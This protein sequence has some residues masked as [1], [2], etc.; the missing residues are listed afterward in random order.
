LKDNHD[1]LIAKCQEGDIQAFK[2]LYETEKEKVYN[3]CFRIHGN[4]HD[5]QDSVQDAFVLTFNKIKTFRGDAAFSTWFYRIIVNT[6]L[7]NIRRS[8]RHSNSRSLDDFEIE[9]ERKVQ[10][11]QDT[12]VQMVLEQEIQQLPTGYRTVFILYEIEGF[13][14]EEIGEILNISTNT[15]KSQLHRGKKI[16]RN[17]LLPFRDHL[18]K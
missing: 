6:C 12:S 16:L 4:H 13:S 11:F 1:S 14:H 5:A 8:K 3:V 15:S 18:F 2:K 10:D 7:N 9:K 17:R